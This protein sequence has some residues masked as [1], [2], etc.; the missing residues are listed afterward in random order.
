MLMKTLYYILIVTGISCAFSS[1]TKVTIGGPEDEGV[2]YVGSEVCKTCHS[3]IY[4]TTKESAM[5]HALTVIDNGPPQIPFGSEDIIPP[6]EYSWSD[7]SLLIGGFE[8]SATFVSND[9]YVVTQ[10]MGSQFNMDD[11]S[12]VHYKPEI[13]NGTQEFVCGECHT[14]GWGEV[15]DEF[16]SSVLNSFPEK[17]YEEGVRCEACHGP[18]SLHLADQ[19]ESSIILDKSSELCA[20]CHQMN[21][22]NSIVSEGRFIAVGQQ[23][24][25][26]YSSGHNEG[27]IGCVGCHNPHASAVNEAATVEGVKPC[28]SCH[29]DKNADNHFAMDIECTVCHMPKSLKIALEQ[30]EYTGDASAHIFNISTEATYDMFSSDGLV[31]KDGLGLSLNYVCYQCHKDENGSGGKFSKKSMADL[32]QKANNF[33]N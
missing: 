23:Y 11:Q 28:S 24:E 8:W 30:N 25:E 4:N 9:G 1:C 20:K 15:T 33:H 16:A 22:D 21:E 12:R 2:K 19:S 14:T 3:E 31:N 5:Y 18:G 10:N 6:D 32:S 29:T 7:L 26:W 17:Y 13:E 27:E